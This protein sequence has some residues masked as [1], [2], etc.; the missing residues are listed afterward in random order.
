[1]KLYTVEQIREIEKL[2]VQSGF[3]EKQLMESAAESALDLIF[4]EMPD[5]AN[6][7]VIF[8]GTGNNG[9]D[10]YTLAK[11][12]AI[13]EGCRV[14]V[15][16]VGP[17]NKLSKLTQKALEACQKV[18]IDIKKFD[19]NEDLYAEIYVDALLGT[20]IKNNVTKEYEKAIEFIN[21]RFGT[22]CLSLDVPSGIDANTGK[23][24]GT[25]VHAD[26][27]ITFIGQKAGLMTGE[28]SDHAG[29]VALSQL[30][31]PDRLFDFFNKSTAETIDP[32]E[33]IF[34]MPFRK[35]HMHKGFFGHVLIIGGD[36]GM[37][38]AP[39]MAGLGALRS[40]AGLVTIATHPEHA[41]YISPNHPELMCYGVSTAA[42]LKPLMERATVI[43]IGPGLGQKTWGKTLLQAAL[44]TMKPLIVDADAL[45]LLSK[46]PIKKDHWILTPHPG[47]AGRL[48]DIE[49]S[50]VQED[51]YAAIR[52]L[53]KR[54]GGIVILKGAGTLIKN[55]I[56]D[57]IKVCVLGNPGMATGGMGDVLT[58]VVAGLVAQD[59]SPEHAAECAV[60]FHAASG[61]TA[62]IENGMRGMM[63][64]DLLPFIQKAVNFHPD[65]FLGKK[66]EHFNPAFDSDYEDDDDF[67]DEGPDDF[68][69]H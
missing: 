45:N 65:I 14:R 8:C 26:T 43:V 30:K 17:L 29:D 33:L 48:L 63:A 42:D 15:R 1:M 67:F 7:I 60:Y 5:N 19:E 59:V 37:S 46:N 12:A 62:A 13:E 68:V 39:L 53:Q 4:N 18:G 31:I 10:G 40:G 20:G 32:G 34:K 47:E 49:T 58:G 54:F 11:L 41:N 69:S 27:N 28:G 55:N 38:G 36:I 22:F 56:D 16:H 57:I 9:G 52:E 35:K 21:N 44:K 24:L 51:R 66:T 6:D 50:Q 61:D 3:S 64:T 2:A 25:A 23:I